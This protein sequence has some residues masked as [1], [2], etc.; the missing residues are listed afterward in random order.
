MMSV[1]ELRGWLA[2][3]ASDEMVG[4]D[5]GGMILCVH[6]DPD[7]YLEIGGLPDEP[8]LA[9]PDLA[10][11]RQVRGG[12]F[13]LTPAEDQ[14]AFEAEAK[15]HAAAAELGVCDVCMRSDV[16]IDHTNTD[17]VLMCVSCAA[18]EGDRPQFECPKCKRTDRID[19]AAWVDVRLIQDG[20]SIETSADDAEQHDTNWEGNS[21]AR[22]CACGYRG[23]VYQFDREEWDPIPVNQQVC[24]F[25][26]V[27]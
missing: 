9:E 3:V 23:K 24:E 26:E 14:A 16:E 27:K 15:A 22:C 2:G 10:E 13:E 18:E 4:I 25:G 17:G 8:E 1:A 5:D 7:H 19:I 20:D 21:P 12:K 11:V 6:G